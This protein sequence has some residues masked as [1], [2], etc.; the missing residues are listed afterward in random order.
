MTTKVS[1]WQQTALGGA[2][3]VRVHVTPDLVI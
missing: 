1:S 3:Q 2:Y